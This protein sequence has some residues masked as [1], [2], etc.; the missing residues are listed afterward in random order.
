MEEV[1]GA[2]I[3]DTFLILMVMHGKLFGIH[4]FPFLKTATSPYLFNLM[5]GHHD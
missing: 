2:A 5:L 3:Q 1:F 4:F